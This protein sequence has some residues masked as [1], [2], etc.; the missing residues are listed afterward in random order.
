LKN[1][2]FVFE[3]GIEFGGGLL[4]GGRVKADFELFAKIK[5]L[6]VPN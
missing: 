3:E 2:L 5:G 6:P 4:V 1:L